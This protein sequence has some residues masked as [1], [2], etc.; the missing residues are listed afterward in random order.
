MLQFKKKKKGE[1]AKEVSRK[2]PT[3][4]M[5]G[6]CGGKAWWD[7]RPPGKEKPQEGRVRARSASMG[8]RETGE[9]SSSGGEREGQGHTL[10][11][12]QLQRT[13]VERGGL[14]ELAVA[15]A[16]V[17]GG[18]ERLHR[19]WEFGGHPGAGPANAGARSRRCRHRVLLADRRL[20]G[21]KGFK[22]RV[23]LLT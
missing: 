8:W 12:H 17:A 21:R 6:K 7:S 5:E 19:V 22:S 3:L 2:M 11:L 4:G 18:A 1:R 23:R 14:A 13:A 10:R 15:E 20:S 9:R 16:L